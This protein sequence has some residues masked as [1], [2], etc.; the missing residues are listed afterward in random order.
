MKRKAIR[1]RLDLLLVERGIAK[2]LKEALAMVLA[3]EVQVD[4][5]RTDK[6]GTSIAA[7]ARLLISRSTPED[8]F[9]WTSALLQGGSQT[10]SYSTAPRVSTPLM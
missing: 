10:V 8:V 1:K 9:A 5:K 3:G 7:D 6:V 4:G 2:S